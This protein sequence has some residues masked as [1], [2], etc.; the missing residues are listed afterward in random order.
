MATQTK[1]LKASM[2]KMF[3]WGL[4]ALAVFVTL[5]ILTD[6]AFLPMFGAAA[7]VVWCFMVTIPWVC[8]S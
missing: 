6:Y 5:F 7:S 1:S 8:E 4:F 2:R 3:L